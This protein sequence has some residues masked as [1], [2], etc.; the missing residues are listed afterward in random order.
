VPG[1]PSLI[2]GNHSA[3]RLLFRQAANFTLELRIAA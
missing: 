1:E 2:V 3:L